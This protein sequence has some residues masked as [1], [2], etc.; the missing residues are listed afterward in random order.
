MMHE[1][2]A[3][4]LAAQRG[5]ELQNAARHHKTLRAPRKAKHDFLQL[6]IEKHQVANER[7]ML[8]RLRLRAG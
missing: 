4:Q 2:H 1:L 6:A 3:L 5:P 7:R 8:S